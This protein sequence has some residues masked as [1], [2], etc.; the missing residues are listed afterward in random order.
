MVAYFSVETLEA[1]FDPNR[2]TEHPREGSARKGTFVAREA[3]A[4]V[5]P[6]PWRLLT[7]SQHSLRSHE[8]H[9]LGLLGLPPAAGTSPDWS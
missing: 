5:D 3:P 6:A 8:P 1:R 2:A 4:R 7:G 9:E